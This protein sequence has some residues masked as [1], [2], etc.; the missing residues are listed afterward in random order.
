MDLHGCFPSLGFCVWGLGLS[1]SSAGGL[2]LGV[3]GQGL[4]FGVGLVECK[5]LEKQSQA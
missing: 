1:G 3:Q 2:G 5:N 4:V